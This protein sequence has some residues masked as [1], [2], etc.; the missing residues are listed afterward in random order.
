MATTVLRRN[1]RSDTVKKV[2][3]AAEHLQFSGYK[4]FDFEEP[5]NP[6]IREHYKR[7]KL[8]NRIGQEIFIY[9]LAIILILLVSGLYLGLFFGT[10]HFLHKR[11]ENF[12]GYVAE[13]NYIKAFAAALGSCL[14]A[15]M[16]PAVFVVFFAPGAI[17]SGMT[18]VIS[19]LNGSADLETINLITTIA[20]AMGVFGIVIAGLYSGMDGPV[21]QIGASVGI[22]LTKV[23]RRSHTLRRIFYGE[24]NKRA[25]DEDVSASKKSAKTTIGWKALL[26]FLEQKK[27]RLF[28]TLGASAAIAAV[29]RSPIGGVMFALEEATSFFE[30]SMLLRTAFATVF[31][32]L[33][34]TY[35]VVLGTGALSADFNTTS[36]FS[37]GLSVHFPAK[38][39]CGP[40]IH[41][42]DFLAYIIMGLMAAIIGNAWNWLL[43][44]VQRLR[45]KY[46]IN[47]ATSTAGA[48]GGRNVARKL[49][50]V[51]EVFVVCLITTAVTVL[52][53]LAPG[54]DV[55]T[56]V[57]QPVGHVVPSTPTACG[58]AGNNLA[59]LRECFD[60]I[61]QVCL[62]SAMSDQ[63]RWNILSQYLRNQGVAEALQSEHGSGGHGNSTS[64]EHGTSGSSSGHGT[65]G[66]SESS[67]G[68][69][70]TGSS[71]S[72]AH[73]SANTP[74]TNA[75]NHGSAGAPAGSEN[76]ANPAFSAG[77]PPRSEGETSTEEPD[78]VGAASVNSRP[79]PPHFNPN[80]VPVHG[81]RPVSHSIS[82]HSYAPSHLYYAPPPSRLRH[83][84][85]HYGP[86]T[87]SF[88]ANLHKL[89]R[90]SGGGG[91]DDVEEKMRERLAP[92][93][94]TLPPQERLVP[95][96]VYTEDHLQGK[97]DEA[98]YYELRS[99]LYSSPEVQLDLLLKRGLYDIWSARTLALFGLIYLMLTILTYYIALPTD[100]VIPNLIIGAVAGRA[101]G[102]LVN[103]IKA[104]LIGRMVEDPGVWAMFGMAAAWS[105]TSRL[106]LT[107]AIVCLELTSDFN[108]IP[109]LLVVTISAAW[110]GRFLGPSLYH[111]ELENNEAPFL[112]HEP[113]H[114]LHYR[115]IERAINRNGKLVWLRAEEPL[116]RIREIVESPFSGFPVVEVVKENSPTSSPVSGT[117]SAP[118]P[119]GVLVGGR[120][121]HPRAHTTTRAHLRPIGFVLKD[122]IKESLAYL[123]QHLETI[124]TLTPTLG[125]TNTAST[126][127]PTRTLI[128]IRSLMNVSP[129]IVPEDTVAA[130]VYRNMRHMGLKSVLVVD[131]QGFLV[132]V[133]TRKDL[134]RL[135]HVYAHYDPAKESKGSGGHG[136]DEK[137]PMGGIMRQSTFVVEV[138]AEED[139]RLGSLHS[140]PGSSA[141]IDVGG[142]GGSAEGS[143]SAGDGRSWGGSRELGV[144]EET[145]LL[146]HEGGSGVMEMKETTPLS[147][148]FTKGAR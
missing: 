6:T 45:L 33:L 54:A 13:G 23:I 104:R 131:R 43:G 126:V 134:I 101:F 42:E 11:I 29:F 133:V 7:Q 16:V 89:I 147:V 12:T 59:N 34:V 21:A 40:P 116:Y 98:C 112:D 78:V 3:H 30:P 117:G 55:C 8:Y 31:T 120:R 68:H 119:P 102:L 93:M 58:T 46:I 73:G 137:D 144:G 9:F 2:A 139:Q 145:S 22:L 107:V 70:G 4:S 128:N 79:P 99:L 106:V 10:E 35:S 86:G 125:G 24:A 130:K 82:H 140:I 121:H 95:F 83:P 14:I 142:I 87:R 92:L 129:T 113:S 5:D 76:H 81:I 18:Q 37:S 49:V 141:S 80:I 41:I 62:P 90:R 36:Y 39:D 105:G 32:Y 27:L 108:N 127:D 65:T 61:H 64:G 25:L 52:L 53:P 56:S 69:G 57:R 72:E 71:G 109:G 100:L 115:S 48:R 143:G 97:A 67:A 148:S 136:G 63:Y 47:P 26:S 138:P 96:F 123:E 74:A 124:R 17:G 146:T 60:D 103:N 111:V 15:A 114:P 38:V 28:Y 122:R 20:R 84:N 85:Y 110:L 118:S 44:Q 77:T 132:G 66:N 1:L 75:E 51:L 91:G 50:R 88:T 94:N 135:S 19:F